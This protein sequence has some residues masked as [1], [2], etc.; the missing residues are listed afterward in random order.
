[1]RLNSILV[2]LALVAPTVTAIR[3]EKG[4]TGR[5]LN[6]GPKDDKAKDDK[7]DEFVG[8]KDDKKDHDPKKDDK[9]DHDPKKDDKKDKKCKKAKKAKKHK[10][11][12]HGS[13][14]NEN[15][16]Y[17]RVLI[18]QEDDNV[19]F[20]LHAD[21]LSPDQC[22]E[23][24]GKTN[25][26]DKSVSGGLHID[27]VHSTDQ[28]S[29][30]ILNNVDGILSTD[31]NPRFIGCKDMKA[32]P[33]EP[34]SKEPKDDE[35]RVRR[36]HTRAH[37]HQQRRRFL[38]EYTLVDKPQDKVDVTGVDFEDLDIDRGGMYIL[39]ALLALT[40]NL[41]NLIPLPHLLL[42]LALARSI[43]LHNNDSL[44]NAGRIGQRQCGL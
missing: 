32:P 23:G 40:C 44:R 37:Y 5:Y 20:C 13:S 16:R 26:K 3:G 9:K 18:L 15:R 28:S 11:S 34:K 19:R 25:K 41:R 36:L 22:E 33:K 29:D 42:F 1:M 4:R 2:L 39:V 17:S 12:S 14:D 35:G 6:R 43:H 27:L 10:S 38:E 7:H 8:S 21:E 24:S 30:E 31:T